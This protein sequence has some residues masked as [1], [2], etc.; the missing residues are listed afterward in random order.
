MMGIL[1]AS[2]RRGMAA[3][4][5]ALAVP[6]VVARER[7]AAQGGGGPVPVA[8]AAVEGREIA[9]GQE[10]VGTVLPLRTSTIGSPV[11]E[12]VVE[13]PVNEG[14][15]VRKGD[16]LAQLRTRTLEIQLASARAALE[17]SRQELAELENGT[18][19]E[20]IEQGRA[21]LGRAQALREITQIRSRR[22]MSLRQT[23]SA[24]AEEL[25]DALAEAE[26]AEQAYLEARYALDLLIEGPRSEQ[27][28]RAEAQVLVQE[29]A[30]RG[31][32]DGVENHTIRA[33]FDGYIV[34]EH[35]E[36][37][38]WVAQGAPVV[39]LVE[40]DIVE[41]T[42]PVL[43]DYVRYLVLG[44][45]ARVE[46]GAIPDAAFTGE[47]ARVVPQAELRSRSFPVMVRVENPP[48]E[49]GEVRLK[50]GMFAR[51][52]LPVGRRQRATL[53]PKD[54]LVL[55]GPSPVVLVVDP[56][57]KAANRG[58]VRPVP[59]QLGVA[60]EGF[61]QVTGAIDVGQRVVV[62]GNERLR[63]GQAVA[64]GEP[65]GP[66]GGPTSG[67]AAPSPRQ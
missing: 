56:D 66:P 24:S 40:L 30:V 8:V 22:A 52:T 64:W 50:A 49:D 44:T 51:V 48:Q 21:R 60:V 55:G 23:G 26:Q 37:G 25:E 45:P 42:V 6:L 7:A 65:A 43:E 31:L 36:V 39:D 17:A 38:Q 33:P 9:A 15:R 4:A 19:P 16:V 12:R 29:E 53:V 28:A 67:A 10:F 54:A 61:I 46:V 14:D 41:I 3:G 63:P 1:F 57:P 5:L 27:V 32:E 11:E 35:T 20:E 58:T 2:H 34:A 62:Q 18:R 13:F 59:V 47:V